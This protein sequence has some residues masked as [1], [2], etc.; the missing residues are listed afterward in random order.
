MKKVVVLIR[1]GPFETNRTP[2]ALRITLGLTLGNNQV[3]LLYVGKGVTNLLPLQAQQIQRPSSSESIELFPSCGVRQ[4][5]DQI[6][7]EQWE[8][9]DIQTSIEIIDRETILSVINASDVVIPM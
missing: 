3:T 4:M 6:S 5:A 7:L 9:K 8:I 1:K 2:E